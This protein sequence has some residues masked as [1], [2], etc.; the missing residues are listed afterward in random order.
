MED[1]FLFIIEKVQYIIVKHT[2]FVCY[3]ISQVFYFNSWCN[4]L[5]QGAD[6][7]NSIDKIE[8]ELTEVDSLMESTQRGTE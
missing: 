3:I 4:S 1:R 6:I 2:Q 5:F 7:L 8:K